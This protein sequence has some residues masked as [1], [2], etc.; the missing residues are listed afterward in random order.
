MCKVLATP[1]G[2]PLQERGGTLQ[3]RCHTRRGRRLLAVTGLDDLLRADGVT[4]RME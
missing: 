4:L 3:V 1:A 2:N